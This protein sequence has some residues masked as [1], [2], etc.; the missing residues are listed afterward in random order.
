MALQLL[1]IEVGSWRR[2][3]RD[4]Y[5]D[6]VHFATLC[7]IANTDGEWLPKDRHILIVLGL[8]EE[9][10]RRQLLPGEWKTQRNIGKM[11]RETEERVLVK[12]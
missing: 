2:I 8:V 12:K 3:A 9:R 1:H 4:Y 6:R 5:G 11:K 7:R 10:K